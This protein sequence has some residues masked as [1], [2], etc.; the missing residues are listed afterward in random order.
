MTIYT[1]Y[2]QVLKDLI[3]V[4]NKKSLYVGLASCYGISIVANFQETNVQI[5]H[6][7]GAFNC[8]GMGTVYFWMQSI[9]SHR[10]EPYIT[11]KKAL[12]RTIFSGFCSIFF[13]IV[14]VCVIIS[15][16]LFDLSRISKTYP[17]CVSQSSS[18]INFHQKQLKHSIGTLCDHLES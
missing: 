18:E 14:A 4:L 9:I 17:V 15:H 11:L 2:R 1:R 6:Y 5:M 7:V 12:Y 13:V 16:I 10:L 3:G 8:F